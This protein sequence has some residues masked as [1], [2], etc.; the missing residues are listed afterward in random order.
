MT[1]PTYTYVNGGLI[2]HIR[3][4]LQALKGELHIERA[5]APKKQR[6]RDES[7]MEHH[8]TLTFTV[9]EMTLINECRYW[10]RV[11]TIA[12]LA[13]TDG[14]RIP[15]SRLTGSWQAAPDNN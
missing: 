12:D 1:R 13:D 15:W 9:R 11:I 2:H 10:L 7:I 6:E 3:N 4:R 14:G 8:S 5:W